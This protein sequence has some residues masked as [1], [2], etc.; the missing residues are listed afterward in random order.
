MSH[1]ALH[2]MPSAKAAVISN[3]QLGDIVLLEPL[4]RL[5]AAQTGMPCALYVREAFRPLIELMPEAVWG[6]DQSE[7][8]DFS[9]TTSWSSQAV[10]MTRRVSAK[11]KNLLINQE[12]H[13]CWWHRL[14]FH[15][16]EV[17]PANS[18]YWG[19]Y[20]WRALGGDTAQFISPR[21][22]MPPDSWGHPELPKMPYV[23]INPTA[24]W[25]SKFWV[26]KS[27]GQVIQSQGLPWVMTGGG[28]P[29]EKDHCAAVAKAG[30]DSLLDLAGKT[31]L[32]QYLHALSRARL[33]VCVDGSA[34]HL[35]Q[36]FGV[37]TITIFGPVY[38]ARWHFP[39]P[40]HRILSAFHFTQALPPTCADVPADAVMAEVAALLSVM[41]E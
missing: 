27:W 30:R 39:T 6:P 5:L 22:T 35:A 10:F 21:L 17:V 2:T 23:L 37:P 33:V 9:W 40:K 31:S 41:P 18:E 36:A 26:P 38:P 15:R 12:R 1:E 19:S 24:A 28:T 34:S 4:T 14:F 7:K 8:H 13:R 20:F 16:T 32:K 11:R 25:P 3:K 29:T